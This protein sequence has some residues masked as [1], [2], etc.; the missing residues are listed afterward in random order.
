MRVFEYRRA[1]T[2]Q[3]AFDPAWTPIA[4][5]TD[6]YN[7][8]KDRI[9]EPGRVVDIRGLGLS[10]IEPDGDGLRIGALAT[11]AQV[12]GRPDVAKRWPVLAEAI[13][14]SASP[15]LRN[16]ATVGGNLLQQTRCPYYRAETLLPCHRRRPGSGCSAASGDDRSLAVFPTEGPCLATHPSDPAVALAA[17]DAVVEIAGPAGRRSLALADFLRPPDP[18][19]EP[20]RLSVLERGE[21]VVALVLPHASPH[22]AYVKVR[23][24]WSYEFAVVSAAAVVEHDADGRIGAARVALGGVAAGPWRP[25]RAEPALAGSDPGDAAALR[26]ALEPDFA[27]ARPGRHNAFKVELAMRAAIDA[28]GRA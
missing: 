3:D 5:A 7:L 4:G 8:M 10:A 11:L 22:S 23:D 28:L 15:Q 18:L 16:M 1:C 12:A 25:P 6:L 27:A 17:L 13:A 26:A 20:Q 21:L 9:A 14:A 19:G 2:L 24:R